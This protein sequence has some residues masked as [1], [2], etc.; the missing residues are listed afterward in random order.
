MIVVNNEQAQF[1]PSPFKR[2]TK[3][4]ADNTNCTVLVSFEE[5]K[6]WWFMWI[7]CQAEDS[8]EISSHIFSGK[9]WKNMNVVCCSGD[10]LFKGQSK[11]CSWKY[12]DS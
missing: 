12:T 7:L 3:I 1:I 4:A 9:Q 10:W 11:F 5:N 2:Q 6:A 8:H